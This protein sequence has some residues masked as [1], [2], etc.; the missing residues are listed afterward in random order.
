MSGSEKQC[1]I[2]VSK[3][4]PYFISGNVPLSE[5]IITPKGK[6]Y[7]YK[8]GRK[9][10]QSE[11]YA[12][13]RCGKS[14]NHPFCDGTHIK[15]GFNGTETAS[16]AKYADRAVLI[17]GPELDLMDDTR[18]AYARFCHREDGKVWGLVKN[19]DQPK[20]KEEAIKGAGECPSG[21]L[22]VFDKKENV[23]E[24]DFEPAVELLQDPENGVSGPIHVKGNIPIE[25]A[26]GNIYEIRNRV[27]LCRCGRS[28]NK[29]F[30]DATHV[31]AG[32]SDK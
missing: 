24:P 27:A 22:T 10:P 20:Y 28:R 11:K 19:S 25:C 30:C 23:I 29:P 7:E 17:V 9:F 13:C 3:N 5:K 6:G 21:R 12:L 4:G 32:F 2:K 31:A 15:T 1:K 8:D 16:I 18:C 14:E 26:D